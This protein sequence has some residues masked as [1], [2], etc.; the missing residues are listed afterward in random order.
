MIEH[1]ETGNELIMQ[2]SAIENQTVFSRF[3]KN[4][5]LGESIDSLLAF[6]ARL[7]AKAIP[8][9]LNEGEIETWVDTLENTGKEDE[10]IYWL[11]MV[12]LNEAAL[13]C[14]GNYANCCEYCAAGDL[15]V[16]PREIRVVSKDGQT[17][18]RKWRHGRLSDQFRKN[19][20]SRIAT[21]E[22][23]KKDFHL[24]IT[25][26]A[27]LPYLFSRLEQSGWIARHYLTHADRQM[28]RIAD[29]I[30]FL[31]SFQI[32]DAVTLRKK[33]GQANAET[34]SFILSHLYQMDFIIFREAGQSIV[35]MAEDPSWFSDLLSPQPFGKP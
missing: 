1:P 2:P 14:A 4:K 11:L 21:M 34:R 8:Y 5:P 17:A 29:T 35:C 10:P 3:I 23:F 33:I 18:V 30:G 28:R 15:L 16:N 22:L 25:R 12:R 32:Y 31:N 20:Q 19:G 9:D 27:L 13:L 7:D 26:T 24:E 6:N